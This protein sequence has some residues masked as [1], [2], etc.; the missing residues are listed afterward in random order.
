ALGEGQ[1]GHLLDLAN[2]LDPRQ[3]VP[4]EA[5]KSISHEETYAHDLADRDEVLRELLRLSHRVAM[6]LR[7]D[8]YRARTV[9]AKFRLP[10]FSTLTR[11]KTL[12]DPTDVG[13]DIFG[14]VRAAY[15]G[16][17]PGRRRFRLLGV[18]GSGLVQAGAEQVALIHGGRWGDAERALDRIERRFGAGA[19]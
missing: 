11:S 10:S 14:V 9:T 3:V 15:D 13:A 12:P 19:A 16:L 2:G 6:R 5:P 7:V 4:F 17:A 1:A 8:G 18:A